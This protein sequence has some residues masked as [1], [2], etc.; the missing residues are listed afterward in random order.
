MVRNGTPV[1][2]LTTSA[3][4][5]ADDAI[6]RPLTKEELWSAW[7][8]CPLPEYLQ[9]AEND[10][11]MPTTYTTPRLSYELVPPA[12]VAENHAIR[13]FQIH[14]RDQILRLYT[15]NNDLGMWLKG[16]LS[17]KN[18]RDARRRPREGS[19]AL[20]MANDHWIQGADLA[21]RKGDYRTALWKYATKWSYILPFH[22][23]AFPSDH[24]ML[25]KIGEFD[26]SI[27]NHMSACFAEMAQSIQESEEEGEQEEVLRHFVDM[28]VKCAW[29]TIHYREFATVRSV[30]EA[31]RRIADL[32]NQF[33]STHDPDDDGGDAPDHT[34]ENDFEKQASVLQDVNRDLI[35]GDLGDDKK[36]VI[37]SLGPVHWGSARGEA[38]TVLDSHPYWDRNDTTTGTE[39][40]ILDNLT[41]DQLWVAWGVEPSGAMDGNHLNTGSYQGAL[42]HYVEGLGELLPL[43]AEVLTQ[44]DTSWFGWIQATLWSGIA[45]VCIAVSESPGA[46]TG[47]DGKEVW[48]RLAFMSGYFAWKYKAYT[49]IPVVTSICKN[50]LSTFPQSIQVPK[51]LHF[52][53]ANL[54]TL[55]ETQLEKC[56]LVGD[57]KRH[58]CRLDP[59]YEV[60]GNERMLEFEGLGLGAWVEELGIMK[61]KVFLL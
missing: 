31:T 3:F 47:E 9:A 23:D 18:G 43:H 54:R 40:V 21:F 33:F 24:P 60:T 7:E 19:M 8:L 36:T 35:F 45:N 12:I 59:V 56:A 4:D 46:V 6:P 28:A 53:L 27:F 5:T 16:F 17:W 34:I 55:I 50:L 10:F 58:L 38:R 20:S 42:A 1:E 22:T 26:S 57:D 44:V 14:T 37:G 48:R 11:C 30:Y 2:A 29:V 51:P 61:G 49:T 32:F 25:Q 41:H 39:E 13:L 52:S 15:P